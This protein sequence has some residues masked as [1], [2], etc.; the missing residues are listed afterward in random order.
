VTAPEQVEVRIV[1]F[2][3]HVYARALEHSN[4]LMRE[5]ALIALGQQEDDS[6]AVPRR[7][8]HLVDALTQEY[9][10]VTDETD[11]QRDEALDA[12]LESVDLVYR[13]PPG[14][15]EASRVLAAM[16]EEADDYCRN[17]GS[18]L[19][20]ATPPEAKRFRDWYLGEFVRQVGGAEP[21]PWPE[22]VRR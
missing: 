18:L 1:G 2:P 15:A 3:L 7:L 14:T 5:F 16:L 17:G 10:G 6:P 19:T 21:L 11:A 12:G 8:M 22:Y 20:L 4:E 9:A 13:V